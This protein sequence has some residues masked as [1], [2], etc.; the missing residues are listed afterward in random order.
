MT[1]ELNAHPKTIGTDPKSTDKF[2]KKSG[3]LRVLYII[4][5]VTPTVGITIETPRALSS[6]AQL[7]SF[8]NQKKMWKFSTK[9]MLPSFPILNFML[10]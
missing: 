3:V 7:I 9:R 5:K 4:K 6:K 1:K 8:I 2:T 10:R